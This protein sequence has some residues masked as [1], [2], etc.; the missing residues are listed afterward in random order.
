M[1]RYQFIDEVVALEL[2]P[3]PQ[4]EV[5]KTFLPDDIGPGLSD[6]SRVPPSLLLELMAMTGGRL[7]FHHLWESR[8][9]LLMKVPDCR[10]ERVA[11][12]GSLLHSRAE[13]QGI[14][15]VT[16]DAIMAEANTEVF[17]GTER[18]VW[19]RLLYYCVTVPRVNLSPD[20][21]V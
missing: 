8:L 4:I 11:R 5:R 9:P 6:P 18:I 7:L 20:P 19:G 15:A 21:K 2:R 3:R 10:F 1:R 13:L 14:S 17:V 12:I 16:D